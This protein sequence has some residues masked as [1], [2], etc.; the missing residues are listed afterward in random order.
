MTR[1]EY[2]EYLRRAKAL[3]DAGYKEAAKKMRDKAD[4]YYDGMFE[5]LMK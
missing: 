2:K 1:E 5:G 3:E 4:E